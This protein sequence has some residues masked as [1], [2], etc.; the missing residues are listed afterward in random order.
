MNRKQPKNA[1]EKYRQALKAKP[2]TPELQALF[3][4]TGSQLANQFHKRNDTDNIETIIRWAT[5]VDG[6]FKESLDPRVLSTLK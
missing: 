6:N 3:V 1:M 5:E 2:Y 4:A